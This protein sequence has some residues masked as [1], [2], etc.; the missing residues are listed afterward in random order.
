M[1][2]RDSVKKFVASA[3]VTALAVLARPTLAQTTV[4]GPILDDTTWTAA[5]SPYHVVSNIVVGDDS[6]LTI[7]PGVTVEFDD[8]LGM[9]IGSASFGTGTLIARGTASEPIVFKPS[10]PDPAPGQWR[11]V[12]FTQFA[13]DGQVD[14]DTGAYVSGSIVEHA[15]FTFANNALRFEQGVAVVRDAEMRECRFAIGATL[16]GEQQLHITDVQSRDGLQGIQINRGRGHVLT[17]VNISGGNIMLFIS[18]APDVTISGGLLEGATS[19]GLSTN[20]T[21]RLKLEAVQFDGN[22]A[23]GMNIVDSEDVEIHECSF[24]DNGD[25]GASMSDVPRM[26]IIDC[27]FRSNVSPGTGFPAAAG[28]S[29]FRGED[30]VIEGC[31]F[32]ANDTQQQ[33]LPRGGTLMLRLSARATV[34]DVDFIRNESQIDGGAAYVEESP[35][36]VFSDVRFTNNLS[37]ERGGAVYVL[38]SPDVVFEASTF[39]GNTASD[40]GGVFVDTGSTGISFA[41][42]PDARRFNVFADNMANRGQ[43]MFNNMELGIIPGSGDVD[44]SNVCW[45]TLEQFE[46]QQRIWDGFDDPLLAFIVANPLVDC[47]ACRADI[48]GDGVLTIF[49]FLGY[50]NAFDAG[51]LSVADFDGDGLLT[52]FDFLAFQNEFDAGCP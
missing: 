28:L 11:G 38:E 41:G 48:D 36:V 45:G 52:I 25:S 10:A 42:D 50:Q 19:V 22:P 46:V 23:R 20:R 37:T 34:T 29:I 9:D 7:E 3:F 33:L 31:V 47:D 51:D 6:T 44:A 8:D 30:A 49:D 26:R 18:D 27:E 15:E 35:G 4:G 5:G 2:G 17:R 21:D 24:I 39:E 1:L 14:P 32:E 13:V 40:G 43:D 16:N 12:W